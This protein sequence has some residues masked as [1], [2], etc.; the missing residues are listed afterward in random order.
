MRESGATALST[1]CRQNA[2]GVHASPA[3][4]LR[5]RHPLERDSARAFSEVCSPHMPSRIKRN[6]LKTNDRVTLYPSQYRRVFL[7]SQ[8]RDPGLPRSSA[9]STS[10]GFLSRKELECNRFESQ[11]WK[12]EGGFSWRLILL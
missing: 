5:P 6:L 1:I 12:P 8:L 7:R 4:N 2:A 3:R 11:T 9:Q 10:R